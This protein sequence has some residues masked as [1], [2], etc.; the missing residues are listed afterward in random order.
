VATF[1][2]SGLFVVLKRGMDKLFVAK[3]KIPLE[4]PLAS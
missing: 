2:L 3:L 1:K 4:M